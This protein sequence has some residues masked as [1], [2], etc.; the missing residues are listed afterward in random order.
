VGIDEPIAAH[1]STPAKAA[2]SAT[3]APEADGTADERAHPT[4][5]QWRK[6]FGDRVS[7]Q[8]GLRGII[9]EYLVPVETNTFWYT[10]GGVLEDS[11]TTSAMYLVTHSLPT[12][13]IGRLPFSRRPIPW[14]A[15]A[16]RGRRWRV[17]RGSSTPTHAVYG[18]PTPCRT[19][20]RFA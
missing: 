17:P 18:P 16:R 12:P 13:R 10:L 15:R 11:A 4:G 7:E 5:E 19:R 9:S 3:K 1:S 6:A 8:F 14:R 2:E 20:P